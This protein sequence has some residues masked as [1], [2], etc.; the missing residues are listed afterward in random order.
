MLWGSRGYQTHVRGALSIAVIFAGVL[1]WLLMKAPT[2]DCQVERPSSD[3][4]Y[5]NSVVVQPW[6]GRHQVYG[7][8]ML[9]LHYR[10]G[11]T[12]VGTISI[13]GYTEEF[14][15]DWHVISHAEDVIP[16][17]G[18]YLVRR[19]LSTRVALRFLVKGELGDL[20]LPC[21]WMLELKERVPGLGS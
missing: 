12:Y 19:Y 7:V 18:H 9:P 21:N 2:H 6:L 5:A 8:F 1:G 4:F 14:V 17:P 3:T 13:N 20:R 15:P 16:D 10:S 11:R